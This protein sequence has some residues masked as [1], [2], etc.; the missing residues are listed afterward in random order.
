M[1][2][3]LVNAL[4]A[5]LGDLF[6]TLVNLLTALLD[7]ARDFL[8]LKLP[9]AQL[10]L[11]LVLLVLAETQQESVHQMELGAALSDLASVILLLRSFQFQF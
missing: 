3:H 8:G 7:L 10:Q 6:A 1:A 9:L 4:A 11:P 5:E 2:L